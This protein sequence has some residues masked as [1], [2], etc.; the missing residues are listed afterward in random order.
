M[1]APE[2][3][4]GGGHQTPRMFGSCKDGLMSMLTAGAALVPMLL[5]SSLFSIVP[6]A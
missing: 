4:G 6:L 3:P 1:R 5:F 2:R